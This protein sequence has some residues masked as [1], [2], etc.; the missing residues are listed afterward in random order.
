MRLPPE[1]RLSLSV[2]LG[3]LKWEEHSALDKGLTIALAASI[4]IAGGTLA[5]VVLTPRAGDTFTEF[6][7]LG[8]GGIASGYPANLTVNQTG[9]VTI[10]VNNREGASVSYTIRI[11]LV[12]VVLVHNATSGLNETVPVSNATWTWTN[13]TMADGANCTEPYAFSIPKAGLWKVQFLL[14]KDPDLVDVYRELH[15]YVTVF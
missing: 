1:G 2:D 7:L 14:Y 4:V 3:V 9:H 11:D 15:L 10:G 12:G 13:L 6:Y 8:A 5:Y